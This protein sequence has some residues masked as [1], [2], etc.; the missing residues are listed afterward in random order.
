[1][2]EPLAEASLPADVPASLLARAAFELF[3]AKGQAQKAVQWLNKAAA[4]GQPVELLAQ[5][6]PPGLAVAGAGK[7]AGGRFPLPEAAASQAALKKIREVFKEQYA[8]AQTLADKKALG[9]ALLRQATETND[10]PTVRYVLLR[11]AQSAAVAAGDGPLVRQAIR[12]LAQDFEVE[13]AEEFARALAA[14]ADA[15]LPA[16]VRHAL[17]QAALDAGR[18]ALRADDF[19]YARRLAKTAQL[20]ATKARDAATARQAGDLAATIPWL[21]QEF[22]KAQLAAQRLAE[23]PDHAQANLVLG[24]YTA[25]VKE[26]WN[27][28]LPLLAKGSDNRLRTLAE[29][30]LAL[31]PAPAPPEMIKLGDQ[32]R[33]AIKAVDGPL[34]GAVARRAAFWYGRALPNVSGFTKTYLEQRIASLKELEATRRRP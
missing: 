25:L 21:K 33:A 12:Q 26:D 14:A 16:P 13:E 9:E 23:D 11:E 4:A 24:I 2:T 17:A 5:E 18:Q 1:M 30:E 3:D 32:W 27:R 19:E 29:A 15:V 31:P 10:D 20:L 28:G 7:P 6:L 8:G 22:D 34:Q